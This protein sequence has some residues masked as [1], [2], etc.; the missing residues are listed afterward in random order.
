M[1]FQSWIWYFDL[2]FLNDKKHFVWASERDGF[3]HL[4]LYKVDGTLVRQITQGDWI[5][6]MHGGT[7]E[8]AIA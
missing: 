5:V 6:G 2:R 3:K 7:T 1:I 4:Y 8:K